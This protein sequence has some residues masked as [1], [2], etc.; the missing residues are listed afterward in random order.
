LTCAVLALAALLSA[1]SSLPFEAEI[2]AA[3]VET[4]RIYPV[5]KALVAAVTAVESGF[6]PHAVSR[7][8]AK[9][10]MQLMPS[11]AKRVGIAEREL[12]DPK[13]NILAGARVLAVLL[14]HYDGDLIS[15]LVAYNARPRQPY[16]PVPRNGETPT[17]VWK[18]LGA[19]R[20]F[21]GEPQEAR[22]AGVLY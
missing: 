22:G 13:R 11:T 10:L 20:R 14:R 15:A 4:R 1:A 16:A 7:A 3:L 2:D 8:G 12:F 17:Y 5:P 19:L 18:V 6:R 9:G 21:C